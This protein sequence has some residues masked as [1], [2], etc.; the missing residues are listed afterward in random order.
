[1]MPACST[2]GWPASFGKVCAKPG[3]ASN[4]SASAAIT[5]RKVFVKPRT[6]GVKVMITTLL[7]QIDLRRLIRVRRHR[8]IRRHRLGA[9]NDLGADAVGKGTVRRVI[10]LHHCVVILGR[11][12][13]SVLR[14]ERG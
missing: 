13:V 3:A 12:V 11:D 1:M 10:I 14:S 2:A 9:V 6:N 4:T 8:P 7:P 5:T